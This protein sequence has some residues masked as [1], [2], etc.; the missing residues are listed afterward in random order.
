MFFCEAWR[1]GLLLRATQ[2]NKLSCCQEEEE[3]EALLAAKSK[4]WYVSK[5]SAAEATPLLLTRY[6]F[7]KSKQEMLIQYQLYLLL[8][9]IKQISF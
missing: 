8:V 2:T 5:L 1:E 9:K 3:A 4:L 6:S 7:T